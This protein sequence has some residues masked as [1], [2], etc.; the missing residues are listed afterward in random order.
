MDFDGSRVERLK[1]LKSFFNNSSVC[2]RFS[3]VLSLII[4][5]FVS[6]GPL[7]VKNVFSCSNNFFDGVY[8]CC[9]ELS[10]FT[11]KMPMM[12]IIKMLVSIM[13]LFVFD[14]IVFLQ[15]GISFISLLRSVSSSKYVVD[16]PA[17]IKIA[18]CLRIERLENKSGEK[19]NAVVI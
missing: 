13:T 14:R 8:R 4:K 10:I 3:R 17:I 11:K 6:C 15:F 2:K 16:R 9:A 1:K 19:H 5:K 7:R 18:I 12:L